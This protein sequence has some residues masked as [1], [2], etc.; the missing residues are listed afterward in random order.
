MKSKIWAY[1]LKTCSF[2]SLGLVLL[3]FHTNCMSILYQPKLP[4]AL[5]KYKK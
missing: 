4:D 2:L 3:N 1:L 5:L